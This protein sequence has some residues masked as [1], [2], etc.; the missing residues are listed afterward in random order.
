[1]MLKVCFVILCIIVYTKANS[2]YTACDN[3]NGLCV[4][5]YLCNQ[6]LEDG[7]KLRE[8]LPEYECEHYY[9]SCCKLEN[10]IVRT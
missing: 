3:G 6:E 10:I 1:M 5:F 2:N 8:L 4:L 7:S 9:E